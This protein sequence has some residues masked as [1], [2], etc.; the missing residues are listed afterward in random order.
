[1]SALR[2]IGLCAVLAGLAAACATPQPRTPVEEGWF[3][4][5]RAA[6][7][8]AR[9]LAELRPASGHP[10]HRARNAI[11]FVGDGMGLTTITAARIFEGQARGESG[12]ENSL[13]FEA[14]PYVALA[15]TYSTNLQVSE[16]AATMT[17]M[18]TG[19]KTKAYA[20]GVDERVVPGDWTTVEASRRR[21]LF[22]EAEERGL[23]TGIVT[24]TRVT[25]ATPAACYGHAADRDWE[26]DAGLPPG[27]R[28][29]G[30]PDL[31]RQLVELSTGDG[32]DVVLGGGRAQFLPRTQADPEHPGMRGARLDG[33]DL[34]A[35]W[36]ARR[37]GAL[38]VWSRS[39]LA[40][41]DPRATTRL[42][43]LFEPSHMAFEADRGHDRAGEPSLSEMTAKAVELLARN[44]RGFVLMVEAGRI[45]QA[46]HLGNA[47]RALTETI[48]LSNAVRAALALTDPLETLVVVTADHGHVLTIAGYPLR[49][50]PI[51]GKVVTVDEH[52]EPAEVYLRDAIGR[53]FTT[54]GYAN[55]PGYTGASPEQPEGAKR[56][57]H[58]PTGY[59]GIRRG[60]PDLTRVDTTAPDY[61]QEATVPARNDTHS[62]EDVPIYAGG[63]GA[64]LFHGVQEQSF[65]YHAIVE[66]L[67]WSAP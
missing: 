10:G 36:Q 44:P 3:E 67:G 48:E 65:V 25:H 62:G 19:V 34:V 54:L 52:G 33:R 57:P 4:R 38:Y 43:G 56:Y 11:L 1:M 35:D 53:P 40:A 22:E 8:R 7:A 28:E 17:A 26:D 45:D 29:A 31:A 39:Q 49:G 9:A 59:Q 23:S 63:A 13:A 46:H 32:I 27:A 30:F 20:L 37:P 58:L 66:A 41:V 14:L 60:R 47:Y 16:S 50:N 64:Q 15:K 42:L 61:L 21:T 5:G 12:E 2:P 6:T 18:T 55:G 24:T 51:L